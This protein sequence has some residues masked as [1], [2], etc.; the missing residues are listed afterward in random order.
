VSSINYKVRMILPKEGESP[1]DPDDQAFGFEGTRECRGHFMTVSTGWLSCGD[2]RFV[3]EAGGWI[4][5]LLRDVR[6]RLLHPENKEEEQDLFLQAMK[7]G[8]VKE[9][10][11]KLYENWSKEKGFK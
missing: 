10:I 9:D 7:D 5:L 3:D 11:K 8:N 1:W 2:L 4:A 6:D